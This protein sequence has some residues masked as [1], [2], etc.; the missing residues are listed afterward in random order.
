MG[1]FAD[2]PSGA[3]RT[4][5]GPGFWAN[6]LADWR[7]RKGRLECLFAGKNRNVHLLTWELT[8]KKPASSRIRL[9]FA[10]DFPAK[11]G[12]G[13][14]GFLFGAKGVFHDYRESA[15]RG[16]GWYAG[17][18]PGGT[19]VLAGPKMN[20]LARGEQALPAKEAELRL[21]LL[22]G[23]GGFTVKLTR[24]DPA[25][26]KVLDA[27][28]KTFRGRDFQGNLALSC[29]LPGKDPRQGRV[30]AWFTGW[31][32][33]GPGLVHHPKRRFGPVLFAQYTLSRGT[34]KLT[35]QMPPL[36]E[37][38]ERFVTLEILTPGGKW[39][40]AGRAP[41]DPLARTAR[42]RVKGWDSS[43]KTPYRLSY[44]LLSGKNERRLYTFRG[45]IAAEPP[46]GRPFVLAAFT[47]NGDRGFPNTE[48][49][50]HVRAHH[51]DFLFFSGDQIYEGSGDYGCQRKPL[52]VAVLE[53]L[54]K[55]YL[56]GWAFGSLLKDLPAVAIPDDHDVF[57][58][59]IWGCGGKAVDPLPTHV[60]R[61]DSGGYNMPPAFVNMVQ[62]TQTSH[63]PDPYDPTPV[64]Q[65]ITVYY[66]S[67][68]YGGV[69]FAVIEDRKFKSAPK[70]LLPEADIWNGWPHNPE[71]DPKK[72]A[73]VPGAHLLGKRQLDFLE[74]WAADWSG[75]A[76]MKVVLSQTIFCN[77]ATIPA[78]ARDDNVIPSLKIPKPGVYVKG[79]KIASD[80]DSD[81]WPQTG[82]NEAIRRMRKAFAVH[83]AGDQHL[84]STIQYGV[85]DWRD[86]C[87]AMCVPS[88][89]NIWPR[90]W[91]P[92]EPGRNR[93]PG[94]PAYTGDF[95]DGFGN[96]ITVYAVANP[97]QVDKEFPWLYNRATGYGIARF[98]KKTRKITL[99][100]WPRWVDPA[101]NGAKPYFGW[102]VVLHQQDNFGKKA[103]AWLP[104]IRVSGMTDPVVQVIR[105]DTGAVVYT[106]RIAGTRFQPKVFAPG[107]YTLKVGDPDTKGFQVLRHLQARKGKK[108]GNLEVR[109]PR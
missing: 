44:R 103:A 20:V 87:F 75:G 36:G 46:A 12:K 71:F 11:G 69:S 109:F 89:G 96:K 79:D 100:I 24:L 92:P 28:E 73:D 34:L 91:F 60:A 81:G 101:K 74:S 6:R 18:T 85:E 102:P 78:R 33:S 90:R 80:F 108:I 1:F 76:W 39:K 61:Q 21:D 19:L 50:E 35:A 86:S 94:A 88:I 77:L 66:T 9:G 2:W 38:E 54:R 93:A 42:F 47:G 45:T 99:E 32:A 105:E 30:C 48:I 53:Y 52:K 72:E 14:I 8:G 83:V 22:P 15:V 27:L 59:N 64:K 63:L 23:P 68:L 5:V 62:R 65:G 70:P 37:K 67:I 7:L 43:R 17:I 104:E 26:G 16:K 84:G 58:S 56:Y 107:F 98:E 95:L 106:L 40:K 4:W 49:V 51:P 29:H 97:R 10:P 82:R 25:S 3:D 41:I 13:W 55:W 57:N 31:R